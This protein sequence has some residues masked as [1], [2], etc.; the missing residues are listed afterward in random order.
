L[1]TELEGLVVLVGQSKII[2]WIW[3]RELGIFELVG[4]TTIQ[5]QREEQAHH[6]ESARAYNIHLGAP[7]FLSKNARG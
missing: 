5:H 3:W 2:R 7:C 6:Y 1:A 4:T